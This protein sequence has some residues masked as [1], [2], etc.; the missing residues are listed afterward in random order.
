MSLFEKLNNKRY[1]LQE[2]KNRDPAPPD[3]LDF[4]GTS[5]GFTRANNR[6]ISKRMSQSSNKKLDNQISAR[7]SAETTRSDAINRALGGTSSTEGNA[8]AT[9]TTKPY[10]APSKK[11]QNEIQNRSTLNK[12]Q[13]GQGVNVGTPK[14]TG[15]VIPTTKVKQSEV[16]KAA[17]EFT[18]KINKKNKNRRKG[19]DYFF[20]ADKAKKQRDAFQ[21]GRKAYT[22][23][24][25]GIKAGTPTK[26]G[27]INYIAKARTMRQGSNANV[28][29]NKKAAE[30]IYKS[31]GQKY[32]EKIRKKYETDKNLPRRRPSNAPSYAEVKAKIDAKEKAMQAKAKSKIKTVL[33]VAEK[34]KRG[35]SPFP[36]FDEIPKKSTEGRRIAKQFATAKQLTGEPTK[37]LTRFQKIKK[38]VT[39]GWKIPKDTGNFIEKTRGA[40]KNITKTLTRKSYKPNLVGTIAKNLD[41]VPNRYKALAAAGLIGYGLIGRNKTAKADANAGAGAVPPKK[42][43]MKYTTGTT[44]LKLGGKT[45]PNPIK[46]LP[47]GYDF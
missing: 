45:N 16:S 34:G 27:I 29:A 5:K 28:K 36:G 38:A 39:T 37:P 2:A 18:D 40:G 21:A 23:S 19:V 47:P 10:R 17:K 15:D 41:K 20:D 30:I 22:T 3:G 44:T 31:S 13:K 32:A 25:T 26:Q 43:I 9:T 42:K 11:V 24:K 33:K 14:I 46:G 7:R 35:T 1:N 4:E 6:Q 12:L 8:G